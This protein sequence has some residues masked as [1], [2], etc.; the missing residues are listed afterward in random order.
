MEHRSKA[1]TRE[2]FNK[3]LREF[4]KQ[5]SRHVLIVEADIS[6]VNKCAIF[7]YA[8]LLRKAGNELTA[9]MKKKLDQLTRTKKYCSILDDYNKYKKNDNKKMKSLKGKELKA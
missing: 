1:Y 8:D 3:V 9:V 6:H 2:E 7:C 4:H 5:S